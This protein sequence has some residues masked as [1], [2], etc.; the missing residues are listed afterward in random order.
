[1]TLGSESLRNAV[2]MTYG[3]RGVA[4][5]TLVVTVGS[6]AYPE[7]NSVNSESLAD[8]M[9]PLLLDVDRTAE[10]GR[11]GS[12]FVEMSRAESSGES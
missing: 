8:P 9:K 12:P 6:P 1:M 5:Q 3:G 4:D 7:E 11:Q 2:E 10:L